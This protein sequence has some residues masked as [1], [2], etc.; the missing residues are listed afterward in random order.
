MMQKIMEIITEKYVIYQIN[1]IYTIFRKLHFSFS[2][3][4][5]YFFI[6]IYTLCTVCICAGFSI[7][8]ARVFIFLNIYLSAVQPTLAFIPR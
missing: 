8:N 5:K 2:C 1:L 6:N 3:S 4:L 7:E